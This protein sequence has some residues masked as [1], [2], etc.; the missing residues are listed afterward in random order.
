MLIAIVVITNCTSHIMSINYELYRTRPASIN[1]AIIRKHKNIQTILGKIDVLK[2]T[3][4][5]LGSNPTQ[6][7]KVE[8]E[9][10]RY[11]VQIREHEK[12]LDVLTEMQK[13]IDPLKADALLNISAKTEVTSSLLKLY[14][15]KI[16]YFIEVKH[17][18][19]NYHKKL[20]KKSLFKEQ[21]ADLLK[22]TEEN[23]YLLVFVQDAL[24]Q[25]GTYPKTEDIDV[26]KEYLNE[27]IK[28]KEN[29]NGRK[30]YETIWNL[31]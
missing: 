14:D 15:E 3:L 11:E 17:F 4:F 7:Q 5:A 21:L 18:I 20:S 22:Q 30:I 12:D 2:N 29:Y 16:A 28:A 10:R 24:K 31:S 19:E 9:I 6:K 13:N 25:Y 8:T 23:M 27:L 1:T 26:Q